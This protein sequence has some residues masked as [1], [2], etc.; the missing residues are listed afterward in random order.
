MGVFPDRSV[1]G[2]K[3]LNAGYRDGEKS[4][5]GGPSGPAGPIGP[6]DPFGPSAPVGPDAPGKPI[7]PT[8]P[9]ELDPAPI[10]NAGVRPDYS[11]MMYVEKFRR[12]DVCVNRVQ[13]IRLSMF[14]VS[15]WGQLFM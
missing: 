9:S 14:F 8:G 15:I 7:G 2:T 4:W 13:Y 6:S 1:F 3:N 10:E 5:P 11:L 12:D